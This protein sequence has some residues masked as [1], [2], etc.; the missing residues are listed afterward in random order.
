MGDRRW[1]NAQW[2]RLTLPSRG[3]F[4]A[5]GLQAPLMS[6]VRP[7]NM[8]G[9][10]RATPTTAAA[11]GAYCAVV[12]LVLGPAIDRPGPFSTLWLLLGVA[13]VG[14]PAY[15]YV[16]GVAREQMVGL[17]VFQR[18]LLQRFAAWFLACASV[19][20]GFTLAAAVRAEQTCSLASSG[21]TLPSS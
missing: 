16:L 18:P 5:F 19:L 20:A 2:R 21:L 14:A 12:L 4:P 7:P 1:C 6:N 11:T 8:Q 13:L 3:R 10:S 15:F 9:R 17:W